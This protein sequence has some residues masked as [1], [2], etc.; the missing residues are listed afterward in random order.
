M[1]MTDQDMHFLR[2]AIE[3]AEEGMRR[4]DGGPFGAVIVKDNQ[5]VGSGWNQ[6]LKTNDPTAHAE[7]VAIR[8]ACTNLHDYWLEGCR[9]YVSCE[10]CPMCLAAIYWAHINSI[11]FAADR[12][13]A[14]A[15]DFNDAHIYGEVCRPIEGRMIETRQALRSEALQVMQLWPEFDLKRPY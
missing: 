8:S 4:G 12:N 13:D 9:M 6:V 5:V 7:V 14:A 10:P 15:L 3:L 11:M 2:Q 1:K